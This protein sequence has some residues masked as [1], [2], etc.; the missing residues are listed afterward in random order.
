MDYPEF[1]SQVQSHIC[2]RF[3]GDAQVKIFPVVKNNDLKLDSLI[4]RMPGEIITPSIYLN[5]YYER[6]L[7]GAPMAD[8][9]S[10]IAF[11]YE[12][13]RS[14]VNI[15]PELLHDFSRAKELITFRLINT[16]GN[17]ELLGDVPHY[18]YM[19]LSIVFCITLLNMGNDGLSGTVLVHNCH[20]EKWGVTCQQLFE[21][22]YENTPRLL[23]YELVPLSS[24]ADITKA[25]EEDSWPEDLFS[26]SSPAC[27]LTNSRRSFGAA[28]MLYNDILARSSCMCGDDIYI[29]PSSIHEVILVP[30][31]FCPS[32]HYLRS[33]VQEINA[34]EVPA[35][36]VLSDNVYFYSRSL[37]KLTMAS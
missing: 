8:I 27:V 21:L 3:G 11:T 9:V 6:Y 31:S 29:L 7:G 19:D 20:T 5:P 22:A 2:S 28:Y 14:A 26:S 13:N 16:A 34:T 33:I 37:G 36:E 15:D 12:A 4:I 30:A 18:E 35:D 24:A 17:R 10:D 25:G 1:L 23:P 32:A